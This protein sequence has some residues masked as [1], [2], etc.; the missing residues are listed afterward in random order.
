MCFLV[1][2]CTL[3]AQCTRDVNWPI[4]LLPAPTVSGVKQ[5]LS[6]NH[7]TTDFA[8]IDNVF[9]GETYEFDSDIET[10]Y[11]TIRMFGGGT[12]LAHGEVP[13]TLT[14]PLSGTIEMHLSTSIL[15]DTDDFSRKTTIRCLSC[16][17]INDVCSMAI[18]LDVLE[19]LSCDTT[20]YNNIEILLTQFWCVL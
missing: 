6:D 20:I 19:D 16:T 15:C 7:K 4:G 13:L 10:D 2:S 14:M 1:S 18:S 9:W 8:Y 5:S 3:S 17:P 12:I 11:L